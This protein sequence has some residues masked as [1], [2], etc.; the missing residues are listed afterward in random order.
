M[1]NY[2]LFFCEWDGHLTKVLLPGP[3]VKLYR[4]ADKLQP[5]WKSAAYPAG[6]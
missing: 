1:E 6:G 5:D 3:V 2:I 4:N